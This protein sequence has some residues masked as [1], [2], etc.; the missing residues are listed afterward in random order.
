MERNRKETIQFAGKQL[1]ARVIDCPTF[2][3]ISHTTKVADLMRQIS[4]QF[5]L[6]FN[7]LIIFSLLDRIFI[8]PMQ[9]WMA[10]VH[11]N[12]LN[13]WI[14]SLLFSNRNAGRMNG[15]HVRHSNNSRLKKSLANDLQRRSGTT[16]ANYANHSTIKKLTRRS[17]HGRLTFAFV[18][19]IRLLIG[20]PWLVN[21]RSAASFKE[22]SDRPVAGSRDPFW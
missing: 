22:M 5:Q 20:H 10:F 1:P 2:C 7:S 4:E 12:N 13:H 8:S 3:Y 21:W 19:A 15:W 18:T 6:L 11:P 14:L 17:R 16:N 9:L